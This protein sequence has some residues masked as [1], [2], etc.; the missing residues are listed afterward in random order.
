MTDNRRQPKPEYNGARMVAHQLL[1][2]DELPSYL[3]TE[4]EG[5]VPKD[6]NMHR[7]LDLLAPSKSVHMYVHRRLVDDSL[8]NVK[9]LS[10]LLLQQFRLNAL[11]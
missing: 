1:I 11:R 8:P 3:G 9:V 10:I 2:Y 5:V 7:K 4:A 6:S